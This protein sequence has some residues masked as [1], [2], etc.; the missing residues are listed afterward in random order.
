MKTKIIFLVAAMMLLPSLFVTISEADPGPDYDLLI[1]TPAEFQDELEP[2]KDFKDATCRPT[3]IVTLEYIYSH[4]SGYDTAEDVKLCIAD[5]EANHNVK[6]VLLVGDVDK[7]PMR[8][9]YL[10]REVTDEVRWLQYYLTDHYYADLYDSG[11]SFCSWDSD[12]DGIYGEIL[13]TDDDGD[14]DFNDG[15][16]FT[17]D[18][19]V[20]RIPVNTGTE[21]TTYVDKVISYETGVSFDDAWFKNIILATAATAGWVYPSLPTTYDEDQNDLIATT[22]SPLGFTAHKIYHSVTPASDPHY[23]TSAH[24]NTHLNDGAGFM[25]VISHGSPVSW[26]VYDVTSDM[27]GLTN[28][29][30]LTIIYSF[31]CST[32]KVGPICPADDYIDIWGTKQTDSYLYS[33]PVP[34]SSWVEPEIPDPLQDS[35]T[36]IA[37]MPE[38]WN[39]YSNDGAVAFVGSTAETSGVMGSPVMQYFFDSIAD[40]DRVLGDVWNSVSLKVESGGHSIDSDWDHARRW[41]YI[42]VF[43]DPTLSIG[44]LD[45]KPPETTMTIGSP[46][47]TISSDI[48]VCG[49]TQFTLSASDD[50]TVLATYYRYYLN[51]VPAPGY[52]TYTGPFTLSGPDG[53]YNIEYYSTDDGGN[54]EYPVKDQQVILDKTSPTTSVEIGSPEYFDGVNTYIKSSTPIST[55]ADDD[56]GSGVYLTYHKVDGGPLSIFYPFTITGEG[57]H[58]ITYYSI[59][60]LGNVESEKTMTVIVDDTPPVITTTVGD[61]K[62]LKGS[63]LWV[64]SSTEITID[65]VDSGSGTDTVQYTLHYKTIDDTYSYTAPFTLPPDSN[66]NCVEFTIDIIATDHLGNQQTDS[67]V[68]WVDDRPPVTWVYNTDPIYFE[69]GVTDHPY[70]TSETEF[71]LV[72]HDEDAYDQGVGVDYTKYRIDGVEPYMFYTLGDT[73]TITGADGLHY[74]NCYSVDFLGNTENPYD[75]TYY[76]Y[77]DNTP[78]EVNI[79]EPEDGDYVYGEVTIEISATDDGSGVNSVEYSLDGGTTWLPATYDSGDIWLGTWDTTTFSE[80]AHTI[81]ARATDNVGNVGDDETPPTVYIVYLDYEIEFSDSNWNYIQDFNVIF[82]EQKPGIYKISTNPG[83]IYEIITITNTGTVVTLP[84]LI[85]DVMIPTETDFLGPGQEAFQFQGAKSVHIYL[86]GVDVTPAGKWI[87]DLS[88]FDVMQPLAPGDTIEIY[89]HYEYAFKGE[90][91]TDPD[92]SSWLGEDYIFIT[93]IL[94]AYGPSWDNTLPAIPVIE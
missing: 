70:I 48:F 68:T 62:Y 76:Y 18:V 88:D 4:Y 92:V 9:F 6:Y 7:L 12:G 91:Y 65:A 49:S 60:N 44:G 26:G 53:T 82:N 57:A 77:L 46:Q 84:E 58:T 21:V 14:Y 45:D 40:G 8:Y 13:D 30:K 15:I 20:G 83:S 93:D 23:P 86:N 63:E 74:F 67:L 31:G 38:Y 69:Y 75:W 72:P 47:V 90:K 35:T 78:P 94:S 54:S 56:S 37:C 80:G 85:L 89:L 39:F 2:L 3:V 71:W 42:N 66:N 51:G 1:I 41:L 27:S 64:T 81:Y 61:P 10:K 50:N 32:A 87:P 43:G 19:V 36:D 29:D 16:D 79:V 59:D 11:G 33:Y 24:I 25:N 52:S 17:F 22:M 55:S 28:D 34:K 73:F 5:Y